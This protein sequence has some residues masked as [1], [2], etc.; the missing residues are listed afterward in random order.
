MFFVKFVFFQ[1]TSRICILC[2]EFHDFFIFL[3]RISRTDFF[4]RI[5]G[6]LFFSKNFTNFA[7]CSKNLSNFRFCLSDNR[8]RLTLPQLQTRNLHIACARCICMLHM[9]ISVASVKSCGFYHCEVR[10][11]CSRSSSRTGSSSSS[12]SSSRSSS[13]ICRN[14]WFPRLRKHMHMHMHR[15]IYMHVRT[16]SHTLHTSAGTDTCQRHAPPATSKA[17]FLKRPAV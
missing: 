6:T 10:Y 2:R 7:F 8:T 1:R 12:S 5:S 15:H 11:E 16:H 17:A 14:Q 9:H 3:L 13:S 4:L